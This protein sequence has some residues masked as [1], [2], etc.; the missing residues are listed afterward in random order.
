[1]HLHPQHGQM[2]HVS[3]I[4]NPFRHRVVGLFQNSNETWQWVTKGD[5]GKKSSCDETPLKV[6]FT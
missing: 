3:C 6:M 5:L 2:I 4:H 1:M